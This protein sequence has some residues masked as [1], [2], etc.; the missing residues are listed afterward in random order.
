MRSLVRSPSRVHHAQQGAP[1]WHNVASR[2]M[3]ARIRTAMHRAVHKDS[4]CVAAS[5]WRGGLQRKPQPSAAQAEDDAPVGRRKLG[6]R[7][8]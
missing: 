2:F 8:L 7:G 3:Y 1:T 4:A 6:G 5:V